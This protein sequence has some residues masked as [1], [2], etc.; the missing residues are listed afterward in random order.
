MNTTEIAQRLVALCREGKWETAQ[1]ELFAPDAVSIEAAASPAFEKETRGLAAIE[2]KGRK[3][4]AMIEQVHSL[5]VS[6][7][8]VAENSFACTMNLDVTMT[9][10][11]RMQI[12]ELCVYGI[13]DGKIASEQFHM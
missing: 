3:W 7:A 4:N 2:E 13:K 11:P 5:A 12:N 8:L 1:K 6:D 10:R 9:G